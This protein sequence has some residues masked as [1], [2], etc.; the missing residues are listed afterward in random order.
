MIEIFTQIRNSC[1]ICKQDFG[2]FFLPFRDEDKEKS[3]EFKLNQ[4]VRAQIYGFK[5]ERSLVQ[6]NTYWSACGFI[7]DS[8]EQ[9]RWNTKEKVDF[10]CRVGTHFVNPD[11]VI[12]KSDG[13]VVFSYRSIAMK[14]LEH[15]EAC[16]YI[17]QAYGVLVDFW[18]AT[19]KDKITTDELIEMVKQAMK[20]G[21][22]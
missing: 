21:E 13:S 7:A 12:V 17:S 8:T 1:P 18:N 4:I 6:L 20:Q 5:K 14:N 9:I 22:K 19:H 15:I 2:L 11:L 16:N 3:R 10:Q